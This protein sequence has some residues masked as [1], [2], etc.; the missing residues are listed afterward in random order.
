M[1]WVVGLDLNFKTESNEK[2]NNCIFGFP[3]YLQFY[4]YKSSGKVTC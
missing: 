1:I 3:D 2:K 4:L